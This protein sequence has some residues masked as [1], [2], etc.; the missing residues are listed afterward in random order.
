MA[1]FSQKSN[2]ISRIMLEKE[3]FPQIPPLLD[4]KATNL[5][6]SL[7]KEKNNLHYGIIGKTRWNQSLHYM[8]NAM[9]AW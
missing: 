3:T 7:G 5:S 4:P 1:K 6:H 2:K 8:C 9:A